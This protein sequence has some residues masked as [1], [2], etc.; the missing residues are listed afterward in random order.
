VAL[1][2]FSLRFFIFPL[3]IIIP[4]LLHVR[5]LLSLE[6]CDSLNHAAHYHI[7][8]TWLDTYQGRQC[9]RSLLQLRSLCTRC[10]IDRAPG[11][12]RI[13]H[14]GLHDRLIQCA[15]KGN[16]GPP[17]TFGFVSVSLTG[18]TGL[19]APHV[20]EARTNERKLLVYRVLIPSG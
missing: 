3:L 13:C 16:Q 10:F 8:S 9:F 1:R 6:L 19:S 20:Y 12:L 15:V 18:Y 14:S 4:S 5:L 7:P 17:C 2:Q 11:T